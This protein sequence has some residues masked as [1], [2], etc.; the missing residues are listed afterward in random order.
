MPLSC[1]LVRVCHSSVIAASYA[2]QCIIKWL[3]YLFEFQ[4]PASSHPQ[5][6]TASL[7]QASF[8]IVMMSFIMGM[9]SFI[10]GMVSFII[11]MMSVNLGG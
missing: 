11:A 8:P 5:L 6:I 7:N 10:R 9:V 4:Q 1:C 2:R 3:F